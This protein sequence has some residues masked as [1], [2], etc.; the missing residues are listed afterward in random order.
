MR[1]LLIV[2]AFNSLTQRVFCELKDMQHVVSVQFCVS[3]KEMIEEV[4]RFKPDIIFSPYLSSSSI[5]GN[6]LPDK[7][8]PFSKS[9]TNV[10]TLSIPLEFLIKRNLSLPD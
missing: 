2:S 7:T 9:T 8:I 1:I 3:D 10:T 6:E 4:G 5:S